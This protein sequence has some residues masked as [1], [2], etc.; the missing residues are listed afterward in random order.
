MYITVLL[1]SKLRPFRCYALY[2][3]V[4]R[5]YSGSI[6]IIDSKW[7]MQMRIAI[8][9]LEGVFDTGLAVVLDASDDSE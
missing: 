7:A 8:L 1:S 9:A 2:S 4:A 5:W 3:V 6:D